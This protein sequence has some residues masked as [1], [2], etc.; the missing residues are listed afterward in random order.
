[1]LL[2]PKLAQLSINSTAYL[3]IPLKIL[4]VLHSLQKW[5]FSNTLTHNFPAKGLK[6]LKRE[7]F[8]LEAQAQ[9]FNWEVNWELG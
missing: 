4:Q 9:Y 1:M 7:V 2:A 3:S 5:Y 6:F 8:Q